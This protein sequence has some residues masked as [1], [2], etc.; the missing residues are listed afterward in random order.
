MLLKV[1]PKKIKKLYMDLD[2]ANLVLTWV[3]IHQE[4]LPS[5]VSSPKNRVVPLANGL[6]MAYKSGLL[7]TPAAYHLGCSSKHM[8][9]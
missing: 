5:S 6:S 4:N 7:T 3:Q 2:L 8:T 9:S 1:S